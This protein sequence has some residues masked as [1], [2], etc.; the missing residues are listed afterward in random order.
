LFDLDAVEKSYDW[1]EEKLGFPSEFQ[2]LSQAVS[3]GLLE[4]G[5]TPLNPQ[6]WL[7][8]TGTQRTYTIFDEAGARHSAASLLDEKNPNLFV[9]TEAR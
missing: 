4:A 5:F 3:D 9:K 8:Q 1:L 7:K 2:P 6:S